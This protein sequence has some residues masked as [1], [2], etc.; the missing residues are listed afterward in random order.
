[1]KL[2][3]ILSKYQKVV[4]RDQ[5][6]ILRRSR[7]RE[8][9]RALL[10]EMV[11]SSS[12]PS[13]SQFQGLY[14]SLRW[15]K[16]AGNDVKMAHW[17]RHFA[18]A[19]IG[20]CRRLT[21]KDNHGPSGVIGG[22]KGSINKEMK[23]AA[24]RRSVILL[25]KGVDESRSQ[26]QADEHLAKFVKTG[27]VSGLGRSVVSSFLWAI[28]PHYYPIVNG[29]N[30]DALRKCIREFPAANDLEDYLLFDVPCLRRF[31]QK[32]NFKDMSE[33]DQTL[34]SI[35]EKVMINADSQFIYQDDASG[36]IDTAIEGDEVSRVVK[37]R[38][39]SARLRQQVL[40]RRGYICQVCGLNPEK[41]YGIKYIHVHHDRHLS[42]GPHKTNPETDLVVVCPS[43][44]AIL[45]CEP[46]SKQSWISLR[47]FVVG[48][49]CCN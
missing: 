20:K 37:G 3:D 42:R 34:C 11:G 16:R 7:A 41:K 24:A 43:C 46:F 1:M 35:P 36:H 18:P 22:A 25:L 44:H 39:R 48:S 26:K 17:K 33:L 12:L 49:K 14:L 29:G 2:E 31:K 8:T 47:S 19:T 21:P 30:I 6:S 32:Y 40:N 10:S 38:L 23:H 45:H 15:V 27:A 4:G 13:P 28:K 5:A 9:F